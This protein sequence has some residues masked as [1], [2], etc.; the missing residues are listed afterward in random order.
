ML[1][2]TYV[3]HLLEQNAAQVFEQLVEDE[4]HFYVCGDVSMAAD[5][6]T[7]LISII[8]T[9]GEATEEEAKE[10]LQILRVSWVRLYHINDLHTKFLST[11]KSFIPSGAEGWVSIVIIEHVLYTGSFRLRWRLLTTCFIAESGNYR[12]SLKLFYGY[13]KKIST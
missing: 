7:R 2:Q 9:C 4:G 5:V 8:Q 1:F 6:K 3:Q 11:N 10:C 12:K 13:I